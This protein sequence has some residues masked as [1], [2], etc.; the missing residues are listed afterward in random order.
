VFTLLVDEASGLLS[1]FTV[2]YDFDFVLFLASMAVFV[3][4]VASRL[5]I[6]LYI[7][8]KTSPEM[9]VKYGSGWRQALG[10]VPTLLEPVS[11]SAMLEDTLEE[12]EVGV[13]VV[14]GREDDDD[15]IC[16]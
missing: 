3:L 10:L 13:G 4:N 9:K 5:A 14:G 7:V 15:Y 12:Q 2:Y 6:G 1:A 16:C 11:G 8:C